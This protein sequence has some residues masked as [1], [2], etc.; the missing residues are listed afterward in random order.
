M[1]SKGYKMQS[2]ETPRT[3]GV[4]MLKYILLPLIMIQLS[5]YG[6]FLKVETTIYRNLL[7][8][9]SYLKWKGMN[10][11]MNY[12]SPSSPLGVK[13][14]RS[15]ATSISDLFLFLCLRIRYR[16]SNLLVRFLMIRDPFLLPL[17][18]LL[19]FEYPISLVHL[20]W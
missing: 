9:E 20:L 12:D 11:R 15:W 5:K 13:K 17:R 7:K 1:E 2:Y 4:I 18:W 6:N 3:K 8:R 19:T 16:Y 14:E 10:L